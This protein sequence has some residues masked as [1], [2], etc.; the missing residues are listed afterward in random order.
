MA[1]TME[2]ALM[3]IV[4]A[5]EASLSNLLTSMRGAIVDARRGYPNVLHVEIRDPDGDRWN[6]VTQDAE[7][8]PI[9]P[10]GLVGQILESAVVNQEG[11]LHCQLSGGT[12]LVVRPPGGESGDDPPY[13]ELITPGGV[14]LEFGPGARWQISSADVPASR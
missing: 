1:E 13:W 2:G 10:D 8:S 4:V 9:D 3:A 6:F 5:Q 12:A 14:A 7:W 11:Q